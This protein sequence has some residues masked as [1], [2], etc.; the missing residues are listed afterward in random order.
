MITHTAAERDYTFPYQISR[1][2][3]SKV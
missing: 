1:F 2:N 3:A